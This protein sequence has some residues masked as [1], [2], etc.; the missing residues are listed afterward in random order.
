[1]AFFSLIIFAGCSIKETTKN[2]PDG[3]DL[4]ERVATY[5]QLKVNEDFMKSYE[6]EAPYY[7]KQ[8]TMINYLRGINTD[9][10][11]Y[12]AATPR[13]I[14]LDADS[15]VVDVELRVRVKLPQIK[16]DEH[17]T[18]IKEKWVRSEGMWYHIPGVI[19]QREVN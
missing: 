4:R 15:A 11:K 1:M 6:Y 7:R 18:V 19:D 14:K 12:L 9:V 5:W 8:T 10:V 13:D 2:G 16:S 3:G 17:S